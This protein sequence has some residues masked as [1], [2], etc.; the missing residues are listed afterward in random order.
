L[1]E[2]LC[3]TIPIIYLFLLYSEFLNNSK[4]EDCLSLHHRWC[5]CGAEGMISGG[6]IGQNGRNN[7][8]VWETM[9]EISSIVSHRRIILV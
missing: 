1:P 6:N 3:W 8:Q 2:A 9:D 4:H 7:F 5:R